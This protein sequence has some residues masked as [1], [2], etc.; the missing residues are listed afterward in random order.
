M[1]R[2]MRVLEFNKMI[3]RL[4]RHAASSLGLEKIE[5][6]KP[7]T[8]FEQVKQ[9][10][11]E[12]DEGA[13]VLR[14]K[15]SVPFGGI[16]DIRASLKR[17]LIGGHLNAAELLDIAETIYGGRR[18]KAFIEKMVEDDVKLPLLHG[19]VS[20]FNPAGELEQ[21][22]K[23]CI[24]EFGE[25]VDSASSALQRVRRE[26]RSS[27]GK[28]REKLEQLTRSSNTRK[29]LSDAVITIRNDRYVIP[30]KQ[31]YR[32][33]FGG[34]VH[35]QSSSGATLFIE[36]ASV[37]EINNR[38]QEAKMK[39]AREIEKILGELSAET[40][41]Y[42]DD[43]LANVERLQHLEFIFAKAHY[44]RELRASKPKM[45]LDGIISFTK[46]RHPLIAEDEVVPIDIMLGGDYTSLIITGP[47]TGGKT[48]TLKTVGLLTLMAQ[49][50]LHIPAEDGSSAALFQSVFADIG[51]EQSIEQNLSTFSSHMT[52]I[53][54]IL[55]NIDRH[56]L[57]LFDELGAGTDPQE[58][59]ALAISILD[60]VHA[61]GAKVIATTHYSELKAYAY[62]RE[63]VLN[64][65]V[66]FD[67]ETL[68]P[69]YRLLIGVPGRS[70][71]FEISRRLGMRESM[72]DDAKRQIA[73]D[74]NKVDRMI[75]SLEE[76][77]KQAEQDRA[78]AQSLLR[79]T[80]QL[81]QELQR[82]I[83][84]LENEKRK[85]LEDAER[86]AKE[87]V[88]EAKVRAEAIIEELR[89][90][91]KREGGAVKEHEWIAARKRLEE[92][93]PQ[94]SGERPARPA[95]RGGEAQRKFA[96]GDE[97]KVISLGQKGH[98]VEQLDDDEYL[99]QLGILKM[100]V[101][102]DDLRKVKAEKPKYSEAVTTVRSSDSHVK[103]ELDLRGK[104]YEEAMHEVEKYLD[105][106][107]LAGYHQVSIIHGK[108]TGALRKGV[109]KWLQNHPN[110]KSTRMGAA[111][112]GGSGVTV[113]QLK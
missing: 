86:R 12:T 78:A 44:S 91:A 42:A 46:A 107:L 38:L 111:G 48:V 45:N 17:S 92:A 40:A 8:D 68:R 89:E 59:A 22:I 98:I 71:A 49:S 4:K 53:V 81:Q 24:D 70:N 18:L 108:G 50:G 54:D 104:R 31:E 6:L 112:E 14:L 58:G 72:I 25:I 61:I 41:Q 28:V 64:A 37:V 103:T 97:V 96:A 43:L 52:N 73:S 21:S 76:N 66:E 87:A 74:S 15:G 2:A 39:E 35:D 27:E 57:V 5:Q 94:L 75:A 93:A 55:K 69:T 79:E 102:A 26:I 23:A 67:V 105:D 29:M 13:K 51:D 11:D 16:H 82:K 84:A 77:K 30:V 106:A 3:D 9:W 80:E 113:A 1:E 99:V 36:P 109:T 83:A 90:A 19:I 10:L 85:V 100:N 95:E 32:G 34:M 60:H 110:V 56:S 47:N 65:S 101:N 33:S 20:Q 63:G 7:S 88:S 62:E